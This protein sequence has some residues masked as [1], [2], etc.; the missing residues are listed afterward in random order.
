VVPKLERV[1]EDNIREIMCAK[2]NEGGLVPT[3]KVWIA[4]QLHL[5]TMQY[6]YRLSQEKNRLYRNDK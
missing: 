1:P 5:G 3:S 2:G 6:H 4:L